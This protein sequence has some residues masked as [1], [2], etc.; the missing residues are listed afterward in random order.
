M[1]SGLGL[2]GA[3]L[4]TKEQALRGLTTAAQEEARNKALEEQIKGQKYAAE[5]SQ[6]ATL[7]STGAAIGYV[8]ATTAS[9]AF[10]ASMGAKFGAAAGPVG[11][12]IGA[13]AGFLFSKIF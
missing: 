4:K 6:A 1:A 12:L 7:G 2:L 10:G 13:A 3:G 8:G 11:A 9:S 5:Q